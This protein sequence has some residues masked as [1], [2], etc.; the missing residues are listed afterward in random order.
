MQKI[1]SN[2]HQSR[3]N[4]S[5]RRHP[6][7]IQPTPLP[8]PPAAPSFLSEV[9]R[10]EWDRLAP[11]LCEMG[12]LSPLDLQPFG[13]YCAAVGVWHD[14]TQASATASPNEAKLLADIARTAARDLVKYGKLFGLSP[15]A[16][17]S[18]SAVSVRVD[19][20]DG[21]LGA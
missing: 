6:K 1:P 9:A 5:K 7:G 21:L 10:A 12:L 3:G 2:I 18:V 16:R 17:S 8:E 14:A 15:N 13:V 19:K 20:F 11:T 4:P